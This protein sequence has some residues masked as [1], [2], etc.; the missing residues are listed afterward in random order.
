MSTT[1]EVEKLEVIEEELGLEVEEVK[2]E[3]TKE[4]LEDE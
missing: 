2:L 4:E 1:V 3:V